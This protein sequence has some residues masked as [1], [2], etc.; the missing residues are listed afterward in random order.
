MMLCFVSCKQ[1]IPEETAGKK[2]EM[3]AEKSAEI[4]DT[5]TVTGGKVSGTVVDD[6]GVQVR[7]FKGIPYAAPPLGE[8]RWKPPQPVKPWAEVLDCTQYAPRAPQVDRAGAGMG[9]GSISED[10]LH[11]NVITAAKTTDDLQPVMVFFHGGGLTTGTGNS[12]LYCNTALPRKGVVVVTVNSRLGPI[13]YMA[14]PALTAESGRNASGNYGTLDLIASLKWVKENITA[15]GGNPDNVLIFGESGGGTKT[16][17]C[18]TSPL[19]AGLFHKAIIESGSASSSPERTT[20]LESGEA[21]GE[22]IVAKLGLEGEKDVLSALRALSWEKIIEAASAQEVN[23]R[24]SLTVDGWV[25]PTSVYD[26]LKNGNQNDV[27]LIVGANEGEEGELL[28]N[29]PRVADLWSSAGKSNVYVYVFSHMP[30]GWRN[31]PCVAFHGLELVYVFGYVPEGLSV[32]VIRYLAPRGGCDP[33]TPGP[34]EKDEVVAENT[35]RLWAQFART[36]NPSV[37]GLITWPPYT[38]ETD[39]YLDVRDPLSV[40]KGVKAAYVAPPER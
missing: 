9:T 31:Q 30:A 18:L 32:P 2:T 1:K 10:C 22:R 24:A 17:S 20:T 36:G 35:M 26:T 38:T 7:L 16:L 4:T 33:M 12:P 13:G 23:F 14:L 39:Q 11:L 19:A 27:P 21:A 25:L 8:L 15:F 6:N 34:D 28:A 40:K 37:E 29:V 5:V 3:M